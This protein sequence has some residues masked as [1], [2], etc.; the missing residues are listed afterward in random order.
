M[1][2]KVLQLVKEQGARAVLICPNWLSS[3]WF[4]LLRTMAVKVVK[5]GSGVE[6]FQA[7]PSGNC[8]PHRNAKWS[9]LA[10]E[11]D[12]TLFQAHNGNQN[13]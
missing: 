13:Q 9:F 4:P 5:L 8:S 6:T 1:I 7:G 12:G 2:D 3:P 11:L 10:V